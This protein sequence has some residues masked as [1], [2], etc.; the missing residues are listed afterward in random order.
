MSA[1]DLGRARQRLINGGSVN[2]GR[3]T[4]GPSAP[5]RVGGGAGPGKSVRCV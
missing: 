4:G 1:V 5:G 3:E 2:L